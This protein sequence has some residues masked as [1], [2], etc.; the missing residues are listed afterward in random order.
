MQQLKE[1]SPTS[2]KITLQL[3][4]QGAQQDF[5]ACM[6]FEFKLTQ[7]FLEHHDFHE[8]VRAALID[9]DRKPIW[10]PASLAEVDDNL[11]SQWLA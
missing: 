10:Q 7:R 11:L 1:K 4:H 8:G 2:L 5:D 3:L 9:K 6:D